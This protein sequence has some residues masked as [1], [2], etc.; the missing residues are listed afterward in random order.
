MKFQNSKIVKLIRKSGAGKQNERNDARNDGDIQPESSNQDG[1]VQQKARELS[2]I[3]D[4]AET[5]LHNGRHGTR[6]G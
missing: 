1:T 4:Q 2:E 6:S 5:K 3:V